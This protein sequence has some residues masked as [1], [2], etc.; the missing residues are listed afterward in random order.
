[1]YSA[2]RCL[3]LG[4]VCLCYCWCSSCR[5]SPRS[6]RAF[7]VVRILPVSA[8][9]GNAMIK[10][11]LFLLV[12]AIAGVAG[13]VALQPDTFRIERRMIV[14]APPQEVFVQVNDFH[15]WD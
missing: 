14:D 11:L 9:S 3:M 7:W 1:M 4:S 2:P 6:C 5:R 12:I 10:K 13:Y 8:F 15:R